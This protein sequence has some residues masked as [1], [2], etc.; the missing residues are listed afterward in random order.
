MTYSVI[1]FDLQGTLSDSEFSDEFW[2]ELLPALYTEHH[3]LTLADSKQVL[4][5]QFTA[6]GKYDRRYYC[7]QYWINELCP[8]SSIDEVFSRLSSKPFLYDQAI[9]LIRELSQQIPL[10]ILSTTT[11]SFIK[12]ELREAETYFQHVFS[13]IDSFDTAGKT[14]AIFEKVASI[15]N[16]SPSNLLHIGDCKEMDISNAQAAGW[17]TYFL[18]KKLPLEIRFEQL[19]SFLADAGFATS[20]LCQGTALQ[21]RAIKL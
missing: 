10:I 11:N 15:L 13:C 18:D 20:K 7:P 8:E 19:K 17:H 16:V 5:Q 9:E 12:C 4:W 2:L 6:M 1:S 21:S 3:T 14:S